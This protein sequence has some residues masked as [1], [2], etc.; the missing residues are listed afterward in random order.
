MTVSSRTSLPLGTAEP[1]AR[2]RQPRW[3]PLLAAAVVGGL[4]G[5]GIAWIDLHDRGTDHVP[6]NIL[7]GRAYMAVDRDAISLT[8]KEGDPNWFFGDETI[9]LGLEVEG[10]NCLR[11]TSNQLVRVAVVNTSATDTFPGKPV[12]VGLECLEQ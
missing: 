12:V 10:A 1:D 8:V 7:V 2:T 4:L 11:P 3:F 6:M 9:G 5:W